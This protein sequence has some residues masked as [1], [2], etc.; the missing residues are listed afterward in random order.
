MYL[1]KGNAS[2]EGNQSEVRLKERETKREG[3]QEKG[4]KG[5]GEPKRDAH[6]LSLFC[7]I[8]STEKESKKNI[9]HIQSL[10]FFQFR[11]SCICKVYM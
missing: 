4:R 6:F 2:K 8:L 5:R 9:N 10:R 3:K 11:L 7:D 1:G